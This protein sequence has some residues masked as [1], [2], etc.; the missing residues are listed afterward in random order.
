MSHNKPSTEHLPTNFMTPILVID[1]HLAVVKSN[2]YVEQLI[3]VGEGHIGKSLFELPDV[4]SSVTDALRNAVMDLNNAHQWEFRGKQNERLLA[5][6]QPTSTTEDEWLFTVTMQTNESLYIDLLSNLMREI[7]LQGVEVLK[8]QQK[9]YSE[10]EQQE[11]LLQS[12]LANMPEAVLVIDNDGYFAL[13]NEA[14]RKMSPLFQKGIALLQWIYAHHFYVPSEINPNEIV[15]ADEQNPFLKSLKGYRVSSLELYI[16]PKEQNIGGYHV[17][18]SIQPLVT[19]QQHLDKG[20]LIIMSDI[21]NRK[22]AEMELADSERRHRALLHT[23]PDTLFRVRADGTYLD[24]IPALN[25][26]IPGATYID[27]NVM[28]LLPTEVAEGL[29]RAITTCLEE[30]TLQIFNFEYAIDENNTYYEVRLSPI[31]D[32]EV[33]GIARNVTDIIMAEYAFE[34]STNNYCS[35]LE[36]MPNPIALVRQDGTLVWYNQHLNKLLSLEDNHQYTVY[37][38]IGIN[39]ILRAQTG[40]QQCYTGETNRVCAFNLVL[41]NHKKTRVNATANLIFYRQEILV[42]INLTLHNK[43]HS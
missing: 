28:N 42:Q 8:Q 4:P 5:I 13:C 21:S 19:Y 20:C 15:L 24:Y 37:D 39:D 38:F 16:K 32:K 18:L 3:N 25:D 10:L 34:R 17:S 33:M 7:E 41:N 40:I 43:K 9:T 30:Q 35:L 6:V 23:L 2:P 29:M 22:Q 11:D 27:N 36:N 31:N 12:I 14:A 1:K 26:I